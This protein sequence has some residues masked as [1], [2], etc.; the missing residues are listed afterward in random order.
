MFF[1]TRRRER[2]LPRVPFLG[3]A[4]R[5]LLLRPRRLALAGHAH[6][7]GALA[8]AG[9]GLGSLS[10]DRKA[11]AVAK[12]AVGADLGQP[13]DV[14]GAVAAQIALNL[15]G[16]DRLAKLHDLVV[17]Q[18]LDVGVRINPGALD[19]LA[20]SGAADPVDVG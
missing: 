11:A 18:V 17:G 2:P 5:V 9:V 12:P 4:T 1:L 19:E 8:A 14:L 15:L 16:L 3:C 7:P 13:L 6:S 10:P 20:G